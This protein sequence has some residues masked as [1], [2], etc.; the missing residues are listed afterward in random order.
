MKISILGLGYVGVVHAVGFA[1][2]G[3]IVLGYDVDPA[4]TE[5]LRERRLPIYEPGLDELWRR[6]R[7]EFRVAESAEEAVLESEATL[8]AVGTPSAP[9]GSADLTYVKSAVDSVGEAL[10][11][12]RGSR[13]LVVIKSTV[14]PGTTAAMRRRL[15]GGGLK[16]GVDFDMAANPEF[17][18]EGN[19]VDDFLRPDRV[20]LGV[21]SDYAKEVLLKMYEGVEGPKIVT[22][23]TTAEFVKYVSN[24]F[25]ALKI[26]FA[27]EVGDMCKAMG[28]DSYEVFKIVGMD[29]RIGPYYFKSGL[30]FGGSCFPK[31]LRAWIAFAKSVGVQPRIAEAAYVVNEER[32]RR[33]VE[34]LKARLGGLRGRRVGVLGLAFKAHTDDIRESRGVE[35]ARLLAEEGA[36]VYVHDPAALENAKRVLGGSVVYVEDPQRLLDEVE[37]VVIAADWPQYER[38]D[39][40]GKVVVDGRRIEKAREA[41]I[42]EGMT[43]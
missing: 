7:G 15:E 16:Y 40:R 8:I 24:V 18:R 19:A 41:K 2:L 10:K 17:L 4:K 38:L 3:H 5:A 12:K 26:S 14:P 29:R 20:V 27:N 32:P 34:L 9:D 11:K 43:W 23:P 31:D 30:G 21:W 28:V 13:H 22:D 33:A 25:L 36:T 39:Y 35:V 37:G 42:Y 1:H 6:A